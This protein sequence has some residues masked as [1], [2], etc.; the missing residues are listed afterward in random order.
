[1][2]LPTAQKL[3]GRLAAAGLLEIGAR[4]RRRLPPRPAGAARSASPTSSRRSRGRSSMTSCVDAERHECALEGCCQVR[5]HMD[6]VNGAVRGALAGRQPLQPRR[7]EPLAEGRHEPARRDRRPQPRGAGGG[8]PRLDLRMGLHLRH[9]AGV[10]AQG[11]QRGHGP[12]HLGQEERAG[13]D[14]RMAAQGLSRLADHGGGDLGQARHPGDRFPGRLLLRRAQGEAEARPRSTR[15]IPRSCR[16]YEKLG[17]PIEEQKV[18]AGVEG[19]RKVAVDAVFDSVSVATTFREELK[20]AGVIFLSISEAIREYPDLVRK[21]LGSVVPQRDNYFACL[22]SAV[23]SDG[24]FV[25]VPEGVRCPMELSHLFP[26]QRREYRPV[27]AHPDRRRQ[28]QLRLLSR[29]LHRADARREPAP[30]GGG[31]ART[32]STM[33]R[34]NIR[35]SRTGIRA[36]PRARAAST[37][38]SPSG[39]CA[40][41]RARRCRW[42]QVETGSA[43]TWKYPSC[44]LKG[45]GSVGEF[46]SVALTNNRQQ[47]DTGTKMIHIGANSRSTIVSKGISAGRSNNTYRGL[48]RV[49][50]GAEN[51]RNFTQCDSPAARRQM[52]RPHRALYRGPQPDRPDRA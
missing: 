31:R 29:R 39:R 13:M 21:Y 37:I 25:Y 30:R 27:R 4:H 34:S 12:L 24:T 43:I 15:S 51:V 17:I 38:S 33:P 46:Y 42:T 1:M 40:P 26:D 48:V 22:N 5:P 32:R 11:P 36:T 9:R 23:F 41:A 2:P 28:G 6:V 44:I 52:R 20:R 18:L 47:A 50:G 7:P 16:V 3:T 19:A 8:R 14:A 35:P 49:N 45:E 10:R